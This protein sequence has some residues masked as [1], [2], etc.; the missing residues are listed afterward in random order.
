MDQRA[1]KVTSLPFNLSFLLPKHWGTW[2]LLFIFRLVALLPLRLSM[3]IGVLL[4][5]VFYRLAKSRKAI[6]QININ[7]CFPGLTE[8]EQQ[9]LVKGVI[10]NVGI[11]FIESA[12]SLWGQSNKLKSQY[13][14]SGLENVE[15]ILSTSQG[16]LL[17]GAH[18]TT[19]D[20]AGRIM[21]YHLSSDM[22]YRRDDK[23][24][25]LAYAIARAREKHS[26]E[27]IPRDN[28]RRLVKNLREG[29]CVWYAQDQDYGAQDIVFA[30]FF[31][32]KTATLTATSR[33]ARVGR[34]RVVP[35][36][37]Y[38]DAKGMY[39]IEIKQALDDFPT[40]DDLADATRINNEI[41]LVVKRFP[42]Q[43]LWVHRRFKTRPAGE[44]PLY[45]SR[46]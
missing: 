29:H 35:F 20:V 17:V 2:I 24:P 18:Y 21:S 42:E 23:N 43:Y 22:V 26:G 41:E 28:M 37:H 9:R 27:C 39:H 5:K 4:G 40:S 38:R 14:I 13:V 15:Q 1:H 32:I 36:A 7:L 11:G 6:T 3:A 19:L 25:V 44:P 34:A 46:E 30:P 12:I 8:H 10:R 45:P 16:V 31:G 33:L